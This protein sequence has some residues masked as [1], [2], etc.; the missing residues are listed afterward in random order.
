MQQL[1]FDY[2]HCMRSAQDDGGLSLFLQTFALHQGSS[3]S[4]R[5]SSAD[6]LA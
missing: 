6:R 3:E 4:V 5:F 1:A 2:A